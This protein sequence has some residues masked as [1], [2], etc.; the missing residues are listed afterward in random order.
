[1]ADIDE[2]AENIY[3]IDDQLYSIPK[4]GSVYLL[5]EEKKALIDTGPG[6]SASA[7]LDGINKIGV[8]PE[9]IAYVIVTHIH[10][11]HA[12]GT[13]V[14]LKEMPRAQ[15][16]VHY[17][18]APHLINPGRLVN[19]VVAVQGK[20]VMAKYGEVL[21]IETHRVQAIHEG[22]TI[23]LGEKQILKFLDTPGHAPHELCI[24]ETRHGGLFVGDAVAVNL[25]EHDILLPFHPPPH[26]NLELCRKTLERLA[27]LAPTK[28]YYS[29][30]GVSHRVQEDLRLA[31]EKLQVWDDIVVEA[32]RDG[33]FDDAGRRLVAQACAEL[34]PV[35]EA[36]S[37]YEYLAKVHIPMCAAGHIKYYQEAL[38]LN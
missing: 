15:V 28:M 29:H 25:V 36:E 20:G 8:R 32:A 5:N 27:K 11:D 12:G 35:K 14:L 4:F 34:E 13:G 37:L 9:D 3:L 33:A 18:G 19:S 24:Y 30:F 38:K 21:P 6:T 7:V 2:V 22:D 17:R 10:L 31:G 16:V 26:F 23:R 1:M